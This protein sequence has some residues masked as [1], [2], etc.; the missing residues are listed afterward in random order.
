MAEVDPAEIVT[1]SQGRSK[2]RR[3][4]DSACSIEMQKERK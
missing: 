1:A 2:I 3:G 4:C